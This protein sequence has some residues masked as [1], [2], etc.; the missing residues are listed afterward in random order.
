MI[1]ER[2]SKPMYAEY[3]QFTKR[4]GQLMLYYSLNYK[5]LLENFL[6]C[7]SEYWVAKNSVGQIAGILPLMKKQGE[8]GLVYNS[9][10][11]YGSNGGVFGDSPESIESLLSHYSHICLDPETACSVYIEN[12]L[13]KLPN[14][15]PTHNFIDKRIGQISPIDFQTEVEDS[16]MNSYHTKTRNMVRKSLKSGLTLNTTDAS[17]EFLIETH[18]EN[19]SSIG[20]KAKPRS[21]FDEIRTCFKFNEDYC[22]YEAKFEGKPIASMLIFK[23]NDCIEYFT[24]VILQE[25]R[26]LQPLSFLIYHAMK[27]LSISGYKYWN[28]GGTWSSQEG[29]YRFKSRW[30]AED[31][32]Y[33]YFI[34][35]NNRDILNLTST[36]IQ[37]AYPNFYL[38]PYSELKVI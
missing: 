24:P 8:Y 34:Q 13:F 37:K 28:W 21:F 1:I 33:M 6:G 30:N 17:W 23:F 5:Q 16:L 38:I 32:E 36:Q 26:S 4:H 3:E 2:L 9:L 15:V 20:G 27:E 11:F 12:P 29:V 25:Y 22:I 14:K 19:M 7:D 35:L 18:H 10:P 31:I